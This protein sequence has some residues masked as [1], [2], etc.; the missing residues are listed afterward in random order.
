MSVIHSIERP[1]SANFL[2]RELTDPSH[3]CQPR[4]FAGTL[5]IAH[6]TEGARHRIAVSAERGFS[7]ERV[8]A[9]RESKPVEDTGRFRRPALLE[10]LQAKAWTCR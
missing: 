9:K 1:A 3:H 8:Q 2:E 5:E 6:V 4:G 10:P 7:Q